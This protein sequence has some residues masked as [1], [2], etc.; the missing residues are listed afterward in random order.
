LPQR[1]LSAGEP[2]I[3]EDL[4]ATAQ[5]PLARQEG[6]RAMAIFPLRAKEKLLGTLCLA[7]RREP[8][9]FTRNERELIRAIGDQAAVAIENARL[10]EQ[11]QELA[12][13]EERN[14]LARELHDSATQSLYGVTMFAEAAARLL[15]A[16]QIEQAAGH[17]R[18]VRATAKEALQEMRLLIFE[19][20]PP[21]LEEQGLVAAL[22]AR[23]E[24]VEGRSGLQTKFEAE[25]V[26]NLPSEVEEALFRIAQEA[27]NNA[28]KH[29]QA[30]KVRV[31]LTQAQQNVT[32]EIT[33][34][35]VGFDTTCTQ[36]GLG[37]AG[38]EERAALLGGRLTVNSEPGGGTRVR[39]EVEN[40]KYL[41]NQEA[42]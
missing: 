22:Q 11:A 13:A 24:S 36:G 41:K 7:T 21:I 27:L 38:M 40:L 42:Q 35:G 6:L 5:H 32:L 8:R 25:G 39:V 1:S 10:Y 18:E 37:L 26:G 14:R 31:C 19:L 2:V 33:D 34:D 9:A 4:L 29:A 17:M 12:A 30:G 28:L 3:V 20:R 15:T 16:G 23:L